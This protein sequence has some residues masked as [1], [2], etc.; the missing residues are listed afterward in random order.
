LSGT[1]TLSGKRN[2]HSLVA[3]SRERDVRQEWGKEKQSSDAII[4]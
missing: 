1:G 3:V 2:L 4:K